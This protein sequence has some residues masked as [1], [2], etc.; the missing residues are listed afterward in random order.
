MN[1][2]IT[3]GSLIDLSKTFQWG[4]QDFLILKLLIYDFPKEQAK[5][6]T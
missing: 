1:K 4:P 3:N 5:C 6:A 2:Y